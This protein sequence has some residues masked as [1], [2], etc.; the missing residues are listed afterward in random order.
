MHHFNYRD[1][2]LHCEEVPL[3]RIADEVGTPVY[4][5]SQATLVRHYHAFDQAF[6]GLDHLV[7]YSVKACSNI[8]LIRLFSDLG[9][10][11]DIVSGGELFRALRAGVPASRIV[12]S[13]VGKT[14]DEIR[15]ALDADI[16][17]FNVESPQELTTLNRI[18][19]DLGRTARIALRVNPDVDAKTHPYI[20]TGLKKNKFGIAHENALAEYRRAMSLPGLEV[21]GID[22]HIGSQLTEVGPFVDAVGRLKDLLDA[23]RTEGMAIRYL[24]LGGGLGITYEAEEPP[25]PAEYAGAVREALA[26]L[27]V[28]LI[29]EPGRVIVGNA[30]VFLTRVLYTKQTELKRFVIV[31]GAMNDLLRPTLYGSFHG[32][33][34][35]RRKEGPRARVDVVGP[36]CETGDFLARD[37]DLPG[38]EAGDL[39][40]VMSAGAYGF[41]MSSNYNSRRKAAEVLVN[42]RGFHVIRRR[43]I[44]EDLLRGEEIPAHIERGG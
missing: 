2:E 13:G 11:S 10:G 28:T 24:D 22:C 34:P 23:L 43:E 1:D 27:D 42:G 41:S 30:A 25:Q 18:A 26:G 36:I 37:R 31:D 16:L 40:A 21:V 35:V 6:E 39:L 44:Y 15:Q 4:V 9:G 14:P 33:E 12:Y 5:Y 7:C 3:A 29:L 19:S 8:S 38:V 20:S 17:M 32:I